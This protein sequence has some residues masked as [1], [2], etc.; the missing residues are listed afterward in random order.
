VLE[1][2]YRVDRGQ[3]ADAGHAGLGLA[4]SRR[5]V[6]LHGGTSRVESALGAGTAFSFD[7]PTIAD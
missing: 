2:D 6:E 7:L 1:R 3:F 5:I 4:I